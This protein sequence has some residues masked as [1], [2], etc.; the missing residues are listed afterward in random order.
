MPDLNHSSK[1]ELGLRMLEGRNNRSFGK[2]R[3]T[4]G[5]RMTYESLPFL[6][7]LVEQ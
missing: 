6:M 2:G 1:G 5:A 4:F 7:E 3:V